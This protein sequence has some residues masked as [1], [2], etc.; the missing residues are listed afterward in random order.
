MGE[1]LC[2]SPVAYVQIFVLCECITILCY[3]VYIQFLPVLYNCNTHI[4]LK[5]M[6]SCIDIYLMWLLV[7]LVVVM[8]TV[9]KFLL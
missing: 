1:V 2:G 7:L 3:C 4:V 8:I 9:I 5:T 6:C